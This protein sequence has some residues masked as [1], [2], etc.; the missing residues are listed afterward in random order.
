MPKCQGKRL[1]FKP[2]GTFGLERLIVRRLFLAGGNDGG[3]PSG[4]LLEFKGAIF[5]TTKGK[6]NGGTVYRIVP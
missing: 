4:D 1:P 6:A 3:V 2:D 5:G